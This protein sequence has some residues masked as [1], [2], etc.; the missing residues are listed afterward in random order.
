MLQEEGIVTATENH[1][2]RV[3][4]IDL[5]DVEAISAQRILLSA[6]ATFLT[7]SSTQ[8]KAA[9][10]MEEALEH[11]EKASAR[12]D[13]EAWHKADLAFHDAH[14]G[15]APLA[16]LNDLAR[17][18]QRDNLYKAIWLRS[19]RHTDSQTVDEH[20]AIFSATIAGDATE[21]MRAVARHRARIG[22]SVMARAVPEREP[23][24][25]RAARPSWSTGSRS[26][27]PTSSSI[28]PSSARSTRARWA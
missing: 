15:L 10:A 13:G 8:W 17:L 20:G 5:N 6:L 12:R 1:R 19:D 18:G 28:T 11:M 26:R 22:L 24:T 3:K 2:V 14:Q 4:E 9:P 25:I 27:A 23:V 7:V 21:A 16:L